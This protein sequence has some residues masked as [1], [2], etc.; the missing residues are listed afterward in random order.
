MRSGFKG[1]M[2]SP[3]ASHS[4]GLWRR[5]HTHQHSSEELLLLSSRTTESHYDAPVLKR[6]SYPLPLKLP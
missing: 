6:L 5:K 4:V 1:D 3:G 2:A